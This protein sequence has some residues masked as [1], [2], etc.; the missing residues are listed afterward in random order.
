MYIHSNFS[1]LLRDCD[2]SD[3]ITSNSKSNTMRNPARE[4]RGEGISLKGVIAVLMI[5]VVI[6]SSGCINKVMQKSPEPG[7]TLDT[8]PEVTAE[9]ATALPNTTSVPD[10]QV[11]IVEMTPARSNG[12]VEVTPIP[13]PDPYPVL[14]ATQIN[15]TP[16]VG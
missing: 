2:N 3:D 7:S 10:V 11:P 4:D 8:S 1:L 13:T 5:L 16:L 14:H 15:S 6:V 9:N 12:I